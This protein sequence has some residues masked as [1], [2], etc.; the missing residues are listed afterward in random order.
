MGTPNTGW[1]RP[2]VPQPRYWDEL[3]S[4]AARQYAPF[5]PVN[6]TAEVSSKGGASLYLETMERML[7]PDAD[8][9]YAYWRWW[10]TAR[11]E[12]GAH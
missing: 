3:V 9:A 11:V 8:P 1:Q 12:G 6:T 4:G 7:A 10:V 5:H 2:V